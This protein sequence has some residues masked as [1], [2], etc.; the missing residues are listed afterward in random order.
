MIIYWKSKPTTNDSY[1]LNYYNFQL[2]MAGQSQIRPD[3]NQNK[4]RKSLAIIRVKALHTN[5]FSPKAIMF[6]IQQDNKTNVNIYVHFMVI[7][8]LFV[9]NS[10]IISAN[11]KRN[12]CY[13]NKRIKVQYKT[14]KMPQ[15]LFYFL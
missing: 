1:H 12:N 14:N 8:I 6:K 9:Q 10:F 2:P 13:S 15:V 4:E 5:G 11:S 3:P 7:T